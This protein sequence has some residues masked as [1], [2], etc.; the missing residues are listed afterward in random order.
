MKIVTVMVACSL[1]ATQKSKIRKC[2]LWSA[3]IPSRPL[4]LLSLGRQRVVISLE[5]TNEKIITVKWQFT[6]DFSGKSKLVFAFCFS[7]S[8]IGIK[9]KKKL[10]ERL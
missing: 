4:F 6:I 10:K 8:Y 1:R 5:M 9:K 3:C 7:E 2:Y